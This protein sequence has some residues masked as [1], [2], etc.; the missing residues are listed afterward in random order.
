MFTEFLKHPPRILGGQ[1][2]HEKMVAIL[3]MNC[4]LFGGA[5]SA[6]RPIDLLRRLYVAE[7]DRRRGKRL[8]IRQMRRKGCR[9]VNGLARSCEDSSEPQ[10]NAAR[11]SPDASA[12][13]LVPGPE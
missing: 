8:Q 6:A 7:R 5:S 13:S 9:D 1:D 11:S 4:G 10:R 3:K 2:V 12:K